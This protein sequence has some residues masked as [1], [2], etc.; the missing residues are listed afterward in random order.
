MKNDEKENCKADI[1][2][3]METNQSSVGPC[4]SESTANPMEETKSADSRLNLQPKNINIFDGVSTKKPKTKKNITSTPRKYTKKS[5]MNSLNENL[6]KMMPI[7]SEPVSIEEFT[8]RLKTENANTQP[9]DTGNRIKIE[10]AYYNQSNPVHTQAT[11]NFNYNPYHGQIQNLTQSGFSAFTPLVNQIMYAQRFQMAAEKL[12][13]QASNASQQQQQQYAQNIYLQN[14][15]QT[16]LQNQ[17]KSH[18]QL[19][20]T[21][22]TQSVDYHSRS[23]AHTSNNQFDYISR[24]SDNTPA[25]PNDFGDNRCT[26]KSNDATI[27]LKE[28][29]MKILESCNLVND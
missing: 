1:N 13:N 23:N 21:T 8:Q 2:V 11:H 29:Q 4:K 9:T 18:H 25:N 10:S 16:F 20:N 19:A 5:H 17:L 6:V 12:K 26:T 3:L 28:T 27:S 22:A 7:K 15:A 24:P 14:L